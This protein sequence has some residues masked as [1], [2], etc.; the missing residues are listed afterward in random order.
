MVTILLQSLS[1][2][3]VVLVAYLFKK[4]GILRSTD[5]TILQKIILNIT[6]PATII[7]GFNAVQVDFILF[8]MIGLG[9]LSNLGLILIGSLFWRKKE[10][11][12]RALMM[13]SQ[14][15]F[16]IGNFTIPF[17]QGFFPAAIPFIGS[18][19]MGNA[20]MLFGGSPMV[21]DKILGQE[22]D[23]SSYLKRV[24]RLFHSPSFTT[25]TFMFLLALLGITVP[26]G[27]TSVMELFASGN[28]FLSMFMV[29]LYLEIDMDSASLKKVSKLL[30]IRY[31]LAIPLAVL[32]YFLLPLPEIVRVSLVL[33][34]LAPVGTV[35][36]INMIVYGNKRSTS[37]F[38]SSISIIISLILM[39]IA[40][41]LLA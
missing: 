34:T 7:I 8:I 31:I 10:P 32:F 19:D 28:A 38:L 40:L 16:N 13:F 23:E 2:L 1:F 11:S 18:F 21:V 5:G 41:T 15:G 12:E 39:T 27:I 33:V 14:G 3:L 9:L 36:T 6:L 29:G 35:S 37:S 22:K 20:L 17:V 4:G 25:Y 30:S 24:L 26:S